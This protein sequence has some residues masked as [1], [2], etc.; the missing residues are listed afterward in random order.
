MDN[1]Y[2]C[3]DLIVFPPILRIFIPGHCKSS[4][5]SFRNLVMQQLSV[6]P[7]QLPLVV[8]FSLHILCSCCII[9]C[10]MPD[11]CWLIRLHLCCL[12]TFLSKLQTAGSASIISDSFQSHTNQLGTVQLSLKIMH[13][14]ELLFA[15]ASW[16][17][18]ALALESC[19]PQELLLRLE[20]CNKF[21]AVGFSNHSVTTSL[22]CN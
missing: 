8:D 15:S 7:I 20:N 5:F 12:C 16:Q 4:K 14:Q 21:F 11:M 18:L 17:L 9:C 1:Y 13:V 10:S 22:R 19:R 3:L 6:A 2:I